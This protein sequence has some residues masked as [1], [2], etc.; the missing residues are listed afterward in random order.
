MSHRLF[1]PAE[2]YLRLDQ[3]VFISEGEEKNICMTIDDGLKRERDIH[4]SLLVIPESNN[5][6]M[7]TQTMHGTLQYIWLALDLLPLIILM[8]YS[9]R[10]Q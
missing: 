8:L 2:V 6:S 10:N 3:S 1:P 4:V 5:S 7:F 9:C